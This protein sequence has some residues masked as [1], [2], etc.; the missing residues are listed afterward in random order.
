MY[1]FSDPHFFENRRGT[2]LDSGDRRI[3]SNI[4]FN[5]PINLNS[6]ENDIDNMK[7]SRN[8]RKI[9]DLKYKYDE[10][11]K[12]A[13]DEIVKEVKKESKYISEAYP[14]VGRQQ[15]MA[16]SDIKLN[17]RLN[18]AGSAL[19]I[20]QKNKLLSAFNQLSLGEKNKLYTQYSRADTKQRRMTLEALRPALR[21]PTKEESVAMK[22]NPRET[23]YIINGTTV[24][25]NKVVKTLTTEFAK[26]SDIPINQP[27]PADSKVPIVIRAP[28]NDPPLVTM[29]PQGYVVEGGGYSI[30]KEGSK[31]GFTI[32]RGAKIYGE[33]EMNSLLILGGIVLVVSLFAMGKK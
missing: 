24:E 11:N 16:P 10:I 28:A 12:K 6:A 27:G 15:F 29:A 30:G 1:N 18:K 4:S 22:T 9:Q 20:E 8:R 32:S 31:G 21:A 5:Q 2:M 17:E 23:S 14:N 33:G 25:D 19:T 26:V 7:P 3:I 13:N